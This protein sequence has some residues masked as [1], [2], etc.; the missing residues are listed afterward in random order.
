MFVV[1]L[2]AIGF[3]TM[4]AYRD[5]ESPKSCDMH[6]LLT[7]LEQLIHLTD[8]KSLSSVI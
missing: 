7:C 3:L 4:H 5:G 8:S 2:G 1:D 6:A